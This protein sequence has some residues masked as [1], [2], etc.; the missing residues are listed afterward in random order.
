MAPAWDCGCAFTGI[1]KERLWE[2]L[3]KRRTNWLTCWLTY[4]LTGQLT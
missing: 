1:N 3:L 4:W 2:V